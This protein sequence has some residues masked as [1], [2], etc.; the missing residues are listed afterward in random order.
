MSVKF[1]SLFWC[2]VIA[3]C[4]SCSVLAEEIA[5]VADEGASDPKD[6]A[7][8]FALSEKATDRQDLKESLRLLLKSANENYTPAQVRLGE[9]MDYSEYDEDAVGWF[10]TAAF[11]GNVKGAFGL[12]KMYAE[13]EGVEKNEGK[14]FFWFKF[15]A[16]RDHIG[17]IKVLANTFELGRLGKKIDLVQAKFWKDKLPALEAAKKREE[18]KLRESLLKKAKEDREKKAKEIKENAA[19]REKFLEQK[20][21]ERDAA[22]AAAAEEGLVGDTYPQGNAAEKPVQGSGK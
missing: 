17:A 21:I 9:Y 8:L 10:M 6:P 14:A 13:G 18:D 4:L 11:Q 20:A 3:S 16:E 19:E 7:E 2:Y 1:K 15:A 22:K 5:K 12:A